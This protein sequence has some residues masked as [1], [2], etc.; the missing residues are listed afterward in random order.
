MRPLARQIVRLLALVFGF[1]CLP[2]TLMIHTHQIG[3]DG[4]PPWHVVFHS[5][6]ADDIRVLSRRPGNPRLDWAT[7][8]VRGPLV[9]FAAALRRPRLCRLPDLIRGSLALRNLEPAAA[10]SFGLEQWPCLA[11]LGLEI[12]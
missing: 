12:R 4:R 11:T 3:V 7:G 8:K 2:Y 9:L 5:G 10:G 6:C 1:S